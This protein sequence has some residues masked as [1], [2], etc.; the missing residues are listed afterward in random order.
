MFAKLL[1]HEWKANSGLRGLVTLAALGSGG[2]GTMV[3]RVRVNYGE[4][5]GN[6]ENVLLNMLLVSLSMGLLFALVALCLYAVGVQF[7]LLYRFYKHKFTDEG[8]LTFT[9]PVSVTQIFWS[10]FVNMVIWLAI[11]L[12]TVFTV[13]FL[14]ILFGT[15]EQGLVNTEI[16]QIVEQILTWI[17]I[18]DWESM[19]EVFGP[20]YDVAGIFYLLQ[21]LITPFYALIVPM[22]CI[23]VGAVLAKKHKIL[24]A[25]G[26]Y[27]GLN[28]VVSIASSMMTMIPSI[29]FTFNPN[30]DGSGYFLTVTL[31]SFLLT[32]GI[33]VG[34][35]FV[36][37]YL[38][39]HK[40]NLP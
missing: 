25:V 37:T 22:A 24:A 32:A 27:Y 13:I 21:M 31:L 34:G 35:Y 10:S 14:V 38:M 30:S 5:L 17:S 9:L 11:S 39:K 40:L 2:L 4:A 12:V 26:V 6:S 19:A 36:T 15:A 20:G 7:I 3:L 33:T 23:T 18:A 29:F 8:Y 1:K 16:F 28:M